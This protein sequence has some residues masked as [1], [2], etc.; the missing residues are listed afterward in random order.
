[1]MGSWNFP[2]YI[3]RKTEVVC[4]LQCPNNPGGSFAQMVQENGR[5]SLKVE[6]LSLKFS[7]SKRH[8]V[9]FVP[10][11]PKTMKSAGFKPWKY[12]L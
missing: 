5:N 8:Y 10:L 1:M 11:D 7:K 2:C 9:E 12:G 6:I 3:L 4:N